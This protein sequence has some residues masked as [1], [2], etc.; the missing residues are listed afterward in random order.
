MVVVFFSGSVINLWPI[1]SRGFSVLNQSVQSFENTF[2]L[3][4]LLSFISN[5]DFVVL[6]SSKV[7]ILITIGK[8]YLLLMLKDKNSI[9][10]LFQNSSFRP[11][12]IFVWEELGV[13]TST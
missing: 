8:L 11:L 1:R 12:P 13:F 3:L 2:G 9:P 6:T 10:N 4:V 7:Q 5:F